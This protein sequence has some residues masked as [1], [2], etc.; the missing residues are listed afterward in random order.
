MID[1]FDLEKV[2][3]LFASTGAAFPLVEDPWAAL[4]HGLRLERLELADLLEKLAEEGILGGIRG[5]PNP[6]RPGACEYLH[7]QIPDGSVV[8]W[9]ATLKDGGELFSL[10]TSDP[11]DIDAPSIAMTKC[12]FSGEMISGQVTSLLAA[13]TDRTVRVPEEPPE[14]EPLQDVYTS[15][16][17]HF[18]VPRQLDP[19]RPF[20]E[21]IGGQVDLDPARAREGARNAVLSRHWRRFSL[22]YNLTNAGLM[23]GGLAEWRLPGKKDARQ[24]A[25]ALASIRGTADVAIRP[26]DPKG[27]HVTALFIGRHPG[28]GE[29]AARTVATQWGL[30]LSQWRDFV[31][32]RV[33]T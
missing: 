24:A 21:W 25:T 29:K 20:W 11:S 4:S 13:E 26:D 16:V 23:G 18:L 7:D 15:M 6:T 19:R 32:L 3:K 2:T 12:G 22:V 5:E 9:K 8:R 31:D 10:Y 1:G 17:E 27:F 30:D 28:D 33:T 14:A